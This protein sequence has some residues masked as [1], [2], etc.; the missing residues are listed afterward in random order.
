MSKYKSLHQGDLIRV[1]FT[2]VSGHE[3]AGYRPAIVVST[4]ASNERCGGMVTVCPISHTVK[5]FPFHVRI[6]SPN[7]EG[8]V[9]CEHVRS[10]DLSTRNFKFLGKAPEGVVQNVMHCIHGEL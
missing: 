4:Q 10:L 9:F 7:V 8:A 5:E 2:P 6:E 3:Q 1:D